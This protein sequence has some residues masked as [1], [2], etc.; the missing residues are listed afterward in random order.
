MFMIIKYLTTKS[1]KVKNLIKANLDYIK[2]GMPDK[3]KKKK[4]REIKED[5]ERKIPTNIWQH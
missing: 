3:K 2:S 1:V 4:P 5:N